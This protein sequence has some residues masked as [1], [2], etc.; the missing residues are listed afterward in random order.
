M[1][2]TRIEALQNPSLT[3]IVTTTI[4]KSPLH[5]TLVHGAWAT[6]VESTWLVEDMADE[7][8]DGFAVT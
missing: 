4:C 2:W 5:L 7:G 8:P 3:L 1:L 6:C